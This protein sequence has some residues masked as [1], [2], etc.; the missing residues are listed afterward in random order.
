MKQPKMPKI[1]G[2]TPPPPISAPPDVEPL[3]VT[4]RNEYMQKLVEL[5]RK[6]MASTILTG[7]MGTLGT[8]NLEKKKL[9]GT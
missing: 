3:E 9:L 4:K 7:G 8:P 6:G 5:R 2:P 1:P